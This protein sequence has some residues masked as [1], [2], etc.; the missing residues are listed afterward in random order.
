[1]HGD[2]GRRHTWRI[3]ADDLRIAGGLFIAARETIGRFIRPAPPPPA[4][5]HKHRA[6][7]PLAIAI[8]VTPWGVTAILLFSELA[9]GDHRTLT[10]VI[11]ILLC[12]MVLNLIGMRLAGQSVARVGLISFLFLGWNLCRI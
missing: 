1:M 5:S 12:I 3:S 4:P 11:G 7:T 2:D 9:Y 6:V 10:I 8:I